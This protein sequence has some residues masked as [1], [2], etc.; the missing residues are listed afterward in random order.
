MRKY[1]FLFV[2]FVALLL[3]SCAF[4]SSREVTVEPA[5]ASETTAYYSDEFL[6]RNGL[7]FDSENFLRGNMEQDDLKE[8]PEVTLHKLNVYYGISEDPKFLRIAADLC[9]VIVLCDHSV[10]IVAVER[11]QEVIALL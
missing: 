4:F 3:A 8:N 11:V 2:T 7:S 6:N 1:R 9:E 5:S 10:R